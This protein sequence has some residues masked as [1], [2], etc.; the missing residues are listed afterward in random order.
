M[1]SG[2]D[3]SV[4]RWRDEVRRR[5]A[6]D[7]VELPASIVDELALHLDDI[8]TAALAEGASVADAEQAGQRALE[9]SAM[10]LLREH[11]AR[12]ERR[13]Q[14]KQADVAA[15]AAARQGSFGMLSALRM[16]VRQ[17]QF[18]PGFALITIAV[19]GLTTGAATTVFTVVDAVVLRPLPYEEPDRLVT[20]WDTNVAQAPCG[21]GWCPTSS[22]TPT[23]LRRVL[24][25]LVS[26]F[27]SDTNVA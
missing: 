5:A 18:R 25:Q 24:V 17:F 19:L 22:R 16:A 13:L 14:Q 4:R 21:A 2:P 7:G 11:A 26:D 20:I 6:A 9:R 8:Y 12:N 10:D 3:P 23:W 15:R 1:P 27:K